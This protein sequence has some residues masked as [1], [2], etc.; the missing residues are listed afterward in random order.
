LVQIGLGILRLSLT[1][2]KLF[3]FFGLHAKYPLKSRGKG[4]SPEKIYSS[5]QTFSCGKRRR[6]KLKLGKS[7][8]AFRRRLVSRS[9]KLENSSAGVDEMYGRH[10]QTVVAKHFGRPTFDVAPPRSNRRHL[11][12]VDNGQTFFTAKVGV[13]PYWE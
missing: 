9:E 6:L 13:A 4:Y 12:H 11:R 7:T 2:Q 5:K 10:G 8:S 3:D 1:D